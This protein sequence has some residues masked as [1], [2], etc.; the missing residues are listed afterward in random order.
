VGQ[1]THEGINPTGT[2]NYNVASVAMVYLAHLSS[3]NKVL[4]TD[5]Y[6]LAHEKGFDTAFSQQFGMNSTQFY[7]SMNSF[8]KNSS[9]A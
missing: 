7:A 5:L 1:E 2:S 4:S 9:L 3:Y 6:A 8:F